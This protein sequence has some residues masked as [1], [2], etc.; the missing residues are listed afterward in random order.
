ML[1]RKQTSYSQ[2]FRAKMEFKP[3]VRGYEAGVVLWWSQ[4]SYASLGVTAS[5]GEDDKLESKISYK[6]TTGKAGDFKV[7]YSWPFAAA[8]LML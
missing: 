2:V 4:Y 7:N 3:T 5:L 1:L 6:G 8:Q